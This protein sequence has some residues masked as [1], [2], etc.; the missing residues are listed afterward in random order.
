MKKTLLILTVFAAL[1]GQGQVTILSNGN[2]NGF[3]FTYTVGLPNTTVVRS[4]SITGVSMT[5]TTGGPA[6]SSLDT[7]LNLTGYDSIK[8]SIEYNKGGGSV[9][10]NGLGNVPLSP[11]FVSLTYTTTNITSLS[12]SCTLTGNSSIFLRKLNITGYPS[13]PTSIKNTGL[14]PYLNVF[15][16]GNTIRSNVSNDYKL[17]VMDLA[18]RIVFEKS[19]QNEIKTDLR[20]GIYILNITDVQGK[21]IENKRVLITE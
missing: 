5:Y 15:T 18:G 16:D 4:N 12:F 7:L 11:A 9:T 13:S 2:M 17:K 20:P 1:T 14:N 10:F 3:N 19:L 8:V 21:L 6:G